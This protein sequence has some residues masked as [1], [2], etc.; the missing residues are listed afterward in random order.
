MKRIVLVVGLVLL[1]AMRATAGDE[2]ANLDSLVAAERA[3]AALSAE[4]GMKQAFL[5]NLSPAAIVF[6]PGP[7]PGVARWAARPESKVRLLWEPAWAEVSGNGDL[8]ITTGPWVV[9]PGDRDTVVAQGRFMTIWE[10][11]PG[12]AWLVALDIG[13]DHDPVAHG[14]FGDVTFEPGVPHPP[15]VF[16]AGPPKGSVSG[17]VGFSSGALGFGI[18]AT[19]SPQEELD[20]VLAHERNRMMNADRGYVFDRRGKGP[21]QALSRVAAPDLWMYRE[22]RLPARGPM[23]AIELL[24]TAP[25]ASELVPFESVVA[26]SFDLGYS[27]G[28][29]LSREKNA[30][31]PDTSGYVHVFR[32]Q[33]TGEWKLIFDVENPFPKRK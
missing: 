7:V 28:L 27:Y 4:S 18:G 24:K 23:E 16:E 2:S 9:K 15:V 33:P 10:R 13:I 21:A 26:T 25:P 20:R 1:G 30:P 22:G 31:R 11:G 29:L 5:A 32:R 14:G 8:G 17:G 6:A 3:F 19:M 12:G